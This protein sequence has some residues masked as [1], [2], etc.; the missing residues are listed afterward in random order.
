MP[1][2]PEQAT[3]AFQAKHIGLSPN[4]FETLGYL[5]TRE[6]IAQIED[7]DLRATAFA[8]IRRDRDGSLYL[9]IENTNEY[10]P[11]DIQAMRE[12]RLRFVRAPLDE[13]LVLLTPFF[14][15]FALA[16]SHL[17]DLMLQHQ[18]YMNWGTH[19][20]LGELREE[21]E[22][23]HRIFDFVIRQ[24]YSATLNHDADLLW[25]AEHAGYNPYAQ[26]ILG[27]LFA[28]AIDHGDE[29][30]FEVLRASAY[31]QHPVG[32]MGEHVVQ[33]LLSAER[34]DGWSV[35]EDLL[36]NAQREEGLRE[37]I[38]RA[39]IEANPLVFRRIIRTMVDHDL[40]RFSSVILAVNQWFKLGYRVADTAVIRRFLRL[41]ADFLDDPHA[42]QRAIKS[43]SAEDAYIALWVMGRDDVKVAAQHAKSLLNSPDVERRYIAVHCLNL[44][45]E[46]SNISDYLDHLDDPDIR[47]GL[48]IL[49]NTNGKDKGLIA[50]ST[51]EKIEQLLA[52]LPK[53]DTALEPLVW[54]WTGITS[55]RKYAAYNLFML[56]EPAYLRRALPYL[57][58]IGGYEKGYI[59]STIIKSAAFAEPDIRE[60]VWKELPKLHRYARDIAFETLRNTALTD[61]DYYHLETLL[62]HKKADLHHIA[63][64]LIKQRSAEQR[65][66][67]AERLL[68][69]NHPNQQIAGLELLL[70]VQR[71]PD[72]QMFIDR[73]TGA[74]AAYQDTQP[75]FTPRAQDIVNE[76]S[77]GV[78]ANPTLDDGLGLFN[79]AERTPP[80]RP[81]PRPQILDSDAAD[82][83][84]TALHDLIIAHRTTSIRLEGEPK[85]R[86]LGQLTHNFPARNEQIPIKDDIKRLPLHEVWVAAYRDRP[87]DQ[88]DPDGLELLRAHLKVM[89]NET[90]TPAK[91]AGFAYGNI[92]IEVLRWLSALFPMK[93]VAEFILDAFENTL[94]AIAADDTA[95]EAASIDSDGR[96]TVR[97]HL[98]GRSSWHTYAI[99][100]EYQEYGR[101]L[102]HDDQMRWWGLLRWID[103]PL[104]AVSRQRPS[105]PIIAYLH[106]QG[107]ATDADVYDALIGSRK[108]DRRFEQH[109]HDLEQL[110]HPLKLPNNPRANLLDRY[111]KLQPIYDRI[112]ERLLE[113]E[114]RRAM[115]P[116]AA[117]KPINS[118]QRL[119]GTDTLLRVLVAL[120]SN[121]LSQSMSDY[122]DR[123]S[124][125]SRLIYVSAP[126]PDETP[127][128]FAAKAAALKLPHER[129]VTV[130]MFVPRWARHIEALLGWEGL[131]SAVYW[132]HAHGGHG[133]SEVY[134]HAYTFSQPSKL[135]AEITAH[136]D[137]QPAELLQNKVDVQW[138]R[139]MYQTLGATRWAAVIKAAKYATLNND[140]ARPVLYSRVLLGEISEEELWARIDSKRHQESVR[141][142]G[143]IPLPEDPLARIEALQRRYLTLQTFL[144]GSRKFGVQRRENEAAAVSLAI[145]RLAQMAGYAD[146]QRL[147]W[148]MEAREASDLQ[149]GQRTETLDGVTLTL[150]IDSAGRADLTVQRAGKALKDIPAKLKKDPAVIELRQRRQQLDQQ[151]SRMRQTFEAA[152]CR[153]EVFTGAELRDLCVHPVLAPMLGQ[154]V[155]IGVDDPTI[156][157]YP[158]EGGQALYHHDSRR[159]PI[160]DAT[161]LRIAHAV[162]LLHGGEWS[163]WQREA[164]T[165]GRVQP[166][167]QVFREVYTVTETEQEEDHA[168][169]RYAGHQVQS[170]KALALLGAR[171]WISHYGE[172]PYKIYAHAGITVSV[173]GLYG[174]GT[175]AMVEDVALETVWFYDRHT[176]KRMALADVPPLVFSEAMRDLDLVVSVAHSSGVDPEATASTLD[177]RAALVHE[178]CALLKLANVKT[179]GR[180]VLVEG[181]LGLYSIHLGSANVHKMPGGSLCIIPVH[182]QHRGRVF[183]PFAD[184]D[185]KTAEVVSKVILLAR[186]SDIKDPVI[187]AQIYR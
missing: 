127:E 164:F 123:I 9:T 137:F 39:L 40:A 142:F 126:G 159:I 52:R 60:V 58:L 185:P 96:P 89:R 55:S 80:L 22:R 122:Q 79:P 7:D 167:K 125:L 43:G 15:R 10:R 141:A 128:Q 93:G 132:V 174:Y 59:F 149:N 178:T 104:T 32:I 34:P 14:P 157:G 182:S 8:L 183:L 158:V 139:R 135:D 156:I 177:M 147:I 103:E 41:T 31:G 63:I 46:A 81:Q 49:Y 19:N 77:N 179:E 91:L 124:N 87:A 33:G 16:V 133:S 83:L 42:L 23:L 168:S 86:L 165:A 113:V 30:I 150:S 3:A 109:F 129:W 4:D 20:A 61:D 138:F 131:A 161:P 82:R 160:G 24:I 166:F 67:S 100:L 116:T 12:A 143:L 85:D 112:C 102:S 84:L 163:A 176:Y 25:W 68:Q 71:D 21:Q 130:A 2:T 35:I 5:R 62:A 181:K 64:S 51:F 170:N 74:L 153:A 146:P 101:Q 26:R 27:K 134:S 152:M 94:A 44:F 53:Q 18:R 66:I 107:I 173:G 48:H 65:L 69:A 145:A 111:P 13:R 92:L 162:D 108:H 184:D 54:P 28:A 75:T 171:N 99:L 151:Y 121:P 120:G 37:T 115:L 140:H 29:Q 90:G 57:P 187:L 172:L 50:P 88:R 180:F 154:L 11:E 119:H 95:Q 73:V 38:L 175:A 118:L 97:W 110:S 148:A 117:S 6:A 72:G 47:I 1:L 56:L 144:R 114:L 17:M 70:S 76:L 105:F 186:D 136:S 169:R 45:G 98:W 106:E 155:F 36:L 78:Q